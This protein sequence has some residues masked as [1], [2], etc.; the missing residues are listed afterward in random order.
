MKK[1]DIVYHVAQK[2]GLTKRTALGIV[3]DILSQIEDEVAKGE[4]V[5]ISGFGVFSRTMRKKRTGINPNTKEKLTIPA[6]PTVKFSA[7]TKFTKKVRHN[8]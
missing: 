8:K 5:V 7:G 6:M 2:Y 3:N 1:I 4:K